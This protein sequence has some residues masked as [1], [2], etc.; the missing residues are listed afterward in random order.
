[1]FD[2][3]KTCKDCPFVLDSSTNKT[4]HPAR[5]PEIKTSLL[6]GQ[7]FPC[8]KT[9][10]YSEEDEDYDTYDRKKEQHCVGAMM[11]LYNKGMPNQMMRIA[12]RFGHLREEGLSTHNEII[13]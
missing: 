3:K 1:M 4:L 2:L 8:H 9:V 11:W 5:I 6:R 13:D 7:S 12:E 10:D